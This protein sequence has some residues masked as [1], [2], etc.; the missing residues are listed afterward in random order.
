MSAQDE[1]Q[2]HAEDRIRKGAAVF[3]IAVVAVIAAAGLAVILTVVLLVTV[4]VH[5]E[6]RRLTFGRERGPTAPARV[7]RLIVGRYVRP[8][9]PEPL[10]ASQRATKAA[11]AAKPRVASTDSGRSAA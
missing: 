11:T 7:A 3:V 10:A 1:P 4:G 8:T 5:Q 6:E 2:G 9:E